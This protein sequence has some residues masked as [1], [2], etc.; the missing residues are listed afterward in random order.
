LKESFPPLEFS[1]TQA[2]VDETIHSLDPAS[3]ENL[4]AGLE[5]SYRFTDLDGEGLSGILT[6][7]GH[8]WFYKPNL[9][10]EFGPPQRISPLPSQANL[11][12]G[13]QQLLDLAGDGSQD[14]V[15]FSG[16][17]PGFYERSDA[18]GWENFQPFA[19]LPGVDW[20][21]PNQRF[22]DLTGDGHA[23]L[24]L[25]GDQ[26]FT[27]Y[28]SLAEQGF[29]PAGQTPTPFDEANG[30]AL[31]FADGTQSIYLADMSGDGLSD[32]VRVRNGEVCYWPNK[33]YG[34]FG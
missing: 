3:L 15:Q 6:E 26:V 5:S 30:P 12:G 34:R 14:L 4:P 19:A 13:S 16:P 1:Y 10:G 20:K 22:I 24:L 27:W 7:Q 33:G 9:G 25:A 32:L 31:V 17:L 21:D 8:A 29:G 28:P 11:S 2:V 18:G 23:D